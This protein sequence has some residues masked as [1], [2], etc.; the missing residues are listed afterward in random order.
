MGI[1]LALGASCVGGSPG[2]VDVADGHRSVPRPLCLPPHP[3][4]RPLREGD[5][6]RE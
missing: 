5:V 2:G 4:H 6:A 1:P 3:L